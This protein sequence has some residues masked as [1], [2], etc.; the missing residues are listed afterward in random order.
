MK[1]LYTS[2]L[3][4]S[5]LCINRHGKTGS[6]FPFGVVTFQDQRKNAIHD[7]PQMTN[8]TMT[9]ADCHEY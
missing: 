6:G 4:H 9:A 2:N 8:I 3:T 7:K 1:S 5:L